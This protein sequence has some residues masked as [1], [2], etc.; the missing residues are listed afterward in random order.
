MPPLP[1]TVSEDA[2]NVTLVSH[3]DM[4]IPWDPNLFHIDN[5]CF[6]VSFVHLVTQPLSP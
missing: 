2:D 3:K 6:S 4:D 1:V 5:V